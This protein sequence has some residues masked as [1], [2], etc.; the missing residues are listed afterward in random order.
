[1][2]HR[3]LLRRHVRSCHPEF[4]L[5]ASRSLK[6]CE[7]C[8]QRKERC[9]GGAP[10]KACEQR[11]LSCSLVGRPSP[12]RRHQDRNNSSPASSAGS[13]AEV[14]YVQIYFDHFHPEWPFLHRPTFD[15]KTEPA[16][17]VQSV[18]MVGMWIQ[19]SRN[20]QDFAKSLHSR[21]GTAIRSQRV[22][23]P[24]LLIGHVVLIFPQNQWDHSSLD[25]VRGTHI[26]CPITTYQSVLLH[27]ILSILMT[28]DSRAVDLGLRH[29]IPAE[30]YDLLMALVRSCQRLG[31]FSYPDMLAQHHPDAPLKMI[32]VG[33][34]EMKR[35]ALALYKVAHICTVMN[36]R[37]TSQ[38]KLLTLADL[39]F[40]TP[41]SDEMWDHPGTDPEALPRVAAQNNRTENGDP[42]EWI[43]TSYTILHDRRVN[44]EWI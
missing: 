29:C 42:K 5:P 16:V 2:P 17:L 9:E 37:E 31:I 33:V 1:M 30:E 27:V 39:S 25:P 19:G 44:F 40:P 24:S 21:L 15:P 6:A 7:A 22:S 12:R 38:E 13:Q 34:E 41:D 8:H 26:S 3:D 43:S 20:S 14:D 36:T 23:T 10:C 11:G 4:E 18:I 28:R 32:W 35:F